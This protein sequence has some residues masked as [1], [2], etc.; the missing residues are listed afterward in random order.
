L[1][2]FDLEEDATIA[3]EAVEAGRLQ[4]GRPVGGSRDALRRRLDIGKSNT[5]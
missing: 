5:V 2:G 4:D 1:K 3:R